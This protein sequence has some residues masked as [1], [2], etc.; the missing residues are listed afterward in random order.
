M[1]KF[2]IAAALAASTLTAAAP[3]AAQYYP[4]PQGYGY[5]GGYNGNG[6][7][8]NYGQVRR[9]QARIDQLQHQISWLDRRDILSEREAHRLR[10]ESRG[11][12]YRLQRAARYSLNSRERYDIERGI[13]RLEYRIQREA[14]DGNR[15][16]RRWSYNDNRDH[17]GDRD[18]W[19]DHDRDGRNDRYEDDQGQ[20]HDD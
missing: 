5:N 18:N 16:D 10:E 19:R 15:Y 9:L 1:R 3:A 13:Q 2:I 7:N 11:L 4:Q 6:Y 14:R 17:W 8:N 12:E 20:D